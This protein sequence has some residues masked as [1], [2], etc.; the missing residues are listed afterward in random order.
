MDPMGKGAVS[1]PKGMVYTDPLPTHSAPEDR[2]TF[3]ETKN[4]TLWEKV[5]SEDSPPRIS[6]E[7][8]IWKENNLI[9]WRL[10]NHGS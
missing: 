10:T 1:T 7:K 8:A 2:G 6:H 3:P 9:L 4:F 5:Y